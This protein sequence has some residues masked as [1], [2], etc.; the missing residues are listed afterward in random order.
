M[1]QEVLSVSGGNISSISGVGWKIVL[2]RDV[3]CDPYSLDHNMDKHAPMHICMHVHATLLMDTIVEKLQL[4]IL[5]A[6]HE[7]CK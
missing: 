7:K 6:F 2:P 3:P 5:A 4:I 1:T